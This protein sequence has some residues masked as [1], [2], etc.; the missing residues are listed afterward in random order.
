MQN[1]IERYGRFMF[2]VRFRSSVILVII[3]AAS[4]IIGNDL[5]FFLLAAVSV[6]G[7]IELYK[8]MNMHKSIPA[9][10][11]YLSTVIYCGL[12]YAQK[13]EHLFSLCII[14][15]LC[16]MG[17]YVLCYPKHVIEKI[18]LVFF[19]LFYV[20]VML[21]FVYQVRMAESGLYL[22]WLIFIGSWGSDT[23]AYL[24]GISI[25]KHKLTK[26]PSPKKSIEGSIGGVI[27]ATLLGLLFATIFKD[28]ITGMSNPLAACAIIGGCS[29]VISQI[30]DLAASAIKRNHD[31]KDFGNLIKGHGGILDRF[32]SVIFTAPIV[33]LLSLFFK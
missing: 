13:T 1:N 18:T 3:L 32:D 15:M 14:F 4:L 17:V 9:V 33:Y 10:I 29:S 12:I 22:V 24:T 25:G 6:I 27:G 8:I 2:W 31:I 26:T 7:L 11:G 21:M 28:K 16:L 19:G 30:G 5:L 20:T 23:C